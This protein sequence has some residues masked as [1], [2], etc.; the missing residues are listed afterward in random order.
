[1]IKREAESEL[2]NLAR[3]F[4][5]IAVIGPRQSGKTTLTRYV[6]HNKPYVKEKGERRKEKGERRKEKVK[7]SIFLKNPALDIVY[8]K[9]FLF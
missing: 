5:A 2:I 7:Q 4:K 3:Q 8:H 1:M 9:N 6:F